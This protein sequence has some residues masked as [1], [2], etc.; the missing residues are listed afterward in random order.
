MIRRMTRIEELIHDWNSQDGG[1]RPQRPIQFDDET[2]RDGLQSPA[3]TDPPLAQKLELL[4]LMDKLGIHTA[5]LGLPGAGGRPREDILSMALHIKAQRLSIGANVACRTVTSDIEPVVEI[6]QRAGMPIEVCAFI[7]SSYIRQYAEDW[8]LEMMLQNTRQALT[9]ARNH[10][11]PVMYVTEDTTRAR[12][13]TIRAL[14]ETAIELG[15]RRLCVCDT[16]GHATPQGARAV[17]KFVRELADQHDK[18]IGIDWH[19]H[20]DRDLGIANCLAAIEA[21][22]DRVHGTALGVGERAGNAP[23]DLLLVNC[24]LQGWIQN[25]LT[26]LPKYVRAAAKA[27]CV[28]IPHNY[29]VLGAD[30]FETGTG[31]HAAAVVKAYRKGDVALADAVYSGVPAHMVGL[32]QHIAVGPM[33]GKSNASFALEKLGIDPTEQRVQMVLAA[34]KSSKRLLTADEIRAAIQN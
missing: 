18:T 27:L 4:E 5:N 12:P 31:V 10:Q 2:L 28:D 11:L 23:M 24:R 20:R 34:G 15:A 19:G 14:Y 30:A 25:D 16:V 8:T 26:T 13:E 21:G 9:F 32:Q 1:T 17:V 7:G 22:A 3:V 33:S 29:P 6:T